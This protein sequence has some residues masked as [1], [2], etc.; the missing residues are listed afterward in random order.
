MKTVEFSVSNIIE[1]TIS[2]E[3][4]RRE[5]IMP[6]MIKDFKLED[7]KDD[8]EPSDQLNVKSVPE[9]GLE[10]E[11]MNYVVE[12]SDHEATVECTDKMERSNQNF[13]ENGIKDE[14]EQVEKEVKVNHGHC[15]F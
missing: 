4:V 9:S 14:D 11:G 1:E 12:K 8:V 10:I 15:N 3:D 5:D 13:I 2:H 7:R 6:N